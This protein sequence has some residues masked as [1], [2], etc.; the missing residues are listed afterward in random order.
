MTF[1]LADP[2]TPAA[3]N[4]PRAGQATV[5]TG[6]SGGRIGHAPAT[7]RRDPDW[8]T[9]HGVTSRWSAVLL[10]LFLSA[11][12]FGTLGCTKD[13]PAF[14]CSTLESCATAGVN[15]LDSCDSGGNRPFCDD[16]GQF[17]PAH[18]CIPDP[19][20][21]ACET[22]D[23]CTTPERPVCDTGDTGT[24]IGCN[25]TSDC[26]R[27]S[28]RNM[29]HPT[30]GACVECTSPAHCTSPT[31]P[32][33]GADG[34][35]RGCNADAECASAVCDELVGACVAEDDII[36]LDR[37]G[38]GT[39]CTRTMPCAAF[40][41][42]IPLISATRR[43]MVV[44]PDDYQEDVVLDS[45]NVTIVGP[46][47]SLHP[48][49]VGPAALL[50]LNAST[51]QIEGLRLYNGAGGT[52]GDGI[53]CAAPVS[54]NPAITL[55]GVTI[56]GNTGFGIDAANCA[57]TIKRS[58]I[59]ANTGGGISVSDS[60]FDITNTFVLGNGANTAVGGVRLMNNATSSIFEFNTVA[61]NVAGSGVAKSLIC[62]AVGTQRIANNIF[63]SG[64]MT[65]VSQTNC[66][67]EFNLSNMGLG[68]SGNI[69]AQPT[70]VGGTDYHLAPTSEGVDDADPGATLTIDFDGHPRPQ[71]AGRDMGADEVM[72]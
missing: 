19:T 70:Y 32:V 60:S 3:G 68:G 61:D 37:D 28:G 16:V 65:Q 23:D 46:G 57:V 26:T 33:C 52:S 48:M 62:A 42:A 53:R 36:Y 38:N 44:A 72:P 51:V 39:L 49:T 29:C 17:G 55:L 30:S 1:H 64:D 22:T 11:L 34:L 14:C 43:F 35:C 15:A 18:T 4:R 31:E 7:S 5:V 47:A 67:L 25:D 2:R 20:A 27:F 54:G 69:T 50:V 9:L 24:C 6:D 63:S 40:T 58:T 66:D 8:Y 41:V 71:G 13:N 45:K 21:P 59:A 12:W 10:S 56:D